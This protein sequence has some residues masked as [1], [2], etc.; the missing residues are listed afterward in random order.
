VLTN[1]PSFPDM[2]AWMAAYKKYDFNSVPGIANAPAV[3]WV[4]PELIPFN[5]A[6]DAKDTGYFGSQV[7]KAARWSCSATGPAHVAGPPAVLTAPLPNTARLT[8]PLP[9]SPPRPF[10]LPQSRFLRLSMQSENC[11]SWAW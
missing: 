1:E 6:N 2:Q 4:K 9:P 5:S 7:S 11:S 10:P 8:A 3:P